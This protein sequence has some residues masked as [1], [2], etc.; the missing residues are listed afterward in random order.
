[1]SRGS[2]NETYINKLS[3]L[4]K[5]IYK[6]E[7]DFLTSLDLLSI[8]LVDYTRIFVPFY[9]SLAHKIKNRCRKYIMYIIFKFSNYY[10]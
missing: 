7:L 3:C 1:M 6:L 2:Y 5:Q 9:M 4:E 8:R 10:L